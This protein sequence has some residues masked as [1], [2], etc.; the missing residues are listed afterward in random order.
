LVNKLLQLQVLIHG[1]LRLELH[2]CRLLQLAEEA[3]AV[4]QVMAEAGADWVT[5]TTIRLCQE[6]PTPLLL[7]PQALF[8]VALCQELAAEILIL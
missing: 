6:T 3:Q 8:L 2:P 4:L 1:L 7:E 5:K